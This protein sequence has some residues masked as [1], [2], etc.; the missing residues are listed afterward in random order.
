MRPKTITIISVPDVTPWSS[1]IHLYT[2]SCA[3][4]IKFTFE[5]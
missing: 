1:Y 5:C 3:V 2:D 4:I